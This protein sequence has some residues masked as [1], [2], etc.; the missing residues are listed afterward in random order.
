LNPLY[1]LVW[2]PWEDDFLRAEYGK[3]SATT[4]AEKLDR[5]VAAV[6][7]RA[8]KLDLHKLAGV[9]ANRDA[10]ASAMR[11]PLPEWMVQEIIRSSTSAVGLVRDVEAA[12]GITA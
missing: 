11:R 12:H 10:K 5:T 6:Y 3:M 2:E 9:R 7:T 1:N 4:I 8:R